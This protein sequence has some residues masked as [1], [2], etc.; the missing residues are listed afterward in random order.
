SDPAAQLM[1]LRQ[2]E[3]VR[4]VDDDGVG[5]RHVD[6]AFD[7]GGADQHV[8]TPMIKVEHELFQVALAHLAVADRDT[9]LGHELANGL[10]RLFDGLYGIVDVVDLTAEPNLAQA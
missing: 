1:D 4:A 8:E 7:D 6:A 2:A 3:P 10:R 9:R 5:G